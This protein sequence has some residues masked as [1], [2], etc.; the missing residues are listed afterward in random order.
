VVE[1]G[2]SAGTGQFLFRFTAKIHGDSS[3]GPSKE[4]ER[5]NERIQEA[6]RVP[7]KAEAKS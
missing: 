1:V 3:T 5:Q 7:E 4:E 2:K 6:H